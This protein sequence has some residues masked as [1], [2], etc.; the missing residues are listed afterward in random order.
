MQVDII[1]LSGFS[2]NTEPDL[3]Q[4]KAEK[5]SAVTHFCIYVKDCICGT[6]SW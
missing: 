6:S 5:Q 1:S 3:S 2:L 4:S